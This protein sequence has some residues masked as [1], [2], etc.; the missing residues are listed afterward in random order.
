MLNIKAFYKLTEGKDIASFFFSQES[1]HLLMT[2]ALIEQRIVLERIAEL[3]QGQH[4]Q[5][6]D[7]EL[8]LDRIALALEER[9]NAFKGIL[10]ERQGPA[11]NP[12]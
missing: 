10:D 5:Y 4:M 8:Q 9:N 3:L 12:G 11:G 6:E 2:I 1:P 7:F